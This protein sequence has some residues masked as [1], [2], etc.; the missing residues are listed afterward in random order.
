MLLAVEVLF[1]A[2]KI[3]P[4][5]IMRG[6]R[7]VFRAFNHWMMCNSFISAMTRRNKEWGTRL[8]ARAPS[9]TDDEILA[10]IS[11]AYINKV[12]IL[13][14][15]SFVSPPFPPESKLSPSPPGG[16]WINTR[17]N[18]REESARGNYYAEVQRESSE[19][20]GCNNQQRK[21]FPYLT[22]FSKR[23]YFRLIKY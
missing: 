8:A 11:D 12:L 7:L 3:I 17:R 16:M 14:E 2:H 10:C 13:S 6:R 18:L 1:S 4:C 19:L 21:M 22:C 15:R 5:T 9:K 20:Q 23:E